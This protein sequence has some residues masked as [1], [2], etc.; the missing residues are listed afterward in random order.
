MLEFVAFAVENVDEER[1]DAW[2]LR[3][4]RRGFELKAGRMLALQ[5]KP[6][7]FGVSVVGPLSPET[8]SLLGIRTEHEEPWK[9]IAGGLYL[10]LRPDRVAA[11]L[12]LL[13]DPFAKFVDAAIA[14]VRREV[15]LDDHA[16]DVITY[17]SK[18]VGRDLPPPEPR[19]ASEEA[20]EPDT[21]DDAPELSREPKNAVVPIFSLAKSHRGAN[22]GDR[23][24]SR[25]YCF[26][27]LQRPFVWEDK[28]VRDLLDSLFIGFPVGTLVLWYTADER[29]ARALGASDRALRATTLV[30]DGQQRL[31]SLFAVMRGVE[32]QDKDGD[33]RF[34][35][36][37]F[38]PR[39]G[40]FEVC[41]AAIRK[42][43]EFLP[44]V[45]ELWRGKK[46]IAQIRKDII[47]A[48]EER[49]RVSTRLQMRSM[50]I[51]DA[52]KELRITDFPRWRS[53]RPHP[54]KR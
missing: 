48:L 33:K 26:P 47:K 15:D 12:D 9:L 50:R 17:L 36:I 7:D 28:Q 35:T 22:R 4:T 39:D 20:D 27:D 49:G 19:Q 23:S 34:I 31:T 5:I 29:E 14:R 13:K 52:P 2:R 6:N 53:A 21:D 43:P 54:P 37:A 44:N 40:R 38:R 41:D 3:E 30:I 24:Q 11:H 16:P 46:T 18:L 42:D 8:S 51:S 10:A 1:S 45:T 32:I 25:G